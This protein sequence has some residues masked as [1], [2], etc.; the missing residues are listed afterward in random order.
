MFVLGHFANRAAFYR[1]DLSFKFGQLTV[2]DQPPPPQKKNTDYNLD[3]VDKLDTTN[4][5]NM[6][7]STEKGTSLIFLPLELNFEVYL[8]WKD[9]PGDFTA[10]HHI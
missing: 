10:D 3:N 9:V 7:F 6:D 2:C 8:V 4:I 1:Y 5:L